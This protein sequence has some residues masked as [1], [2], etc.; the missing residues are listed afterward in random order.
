[1]KNQQTVNKLVVTSTLGVRYIDDEI[2]LKCPKC[3]KVK[4][5]GAFG[6]RMMDNEGGVLRNQP[7]CST[8][9]SEHAR[10]RPR[11]EA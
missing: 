4:A 9:R 2:R 11:R 3:R 1:M 6:V 7:W 10:A 5:L 8:C